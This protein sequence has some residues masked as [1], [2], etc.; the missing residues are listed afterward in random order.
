MAIKTMDYFKENG[1][2]IALVVIETGV[3]T[4]YSRS[5]QQLSR[6]HREYGR[7][8]GIRGKGLKGVYHSFWIGLWMRLPNTLQTR[9]RPLLKFIPF[10][11]RLS[12]QKKAKE[13]GIPTAIVKRHSSHETR[14]LLE[15]N[16]ISYVLLTDSSWLIKEPLLS[17]EK[18]KIINAHCAKLPRH[19]SLDALP[20]SVVENDKLGMTA[21]FVDDG[22]DT[23]PILLFIEVKPQKGDNLIT[24]RERIDNKKPEIFL[25]A[26]QELSNG[27]IYPIPQSKSEG[28][29]HRPMT[30]EELLKAEDVLQC[31]FF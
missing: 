26:I 18:T 25:K 8:M 15:K 7:I 1:I 27:I 14:F 29:N 13:L 30:V 16:D 21:H 17:M 11:N 2:D 31:R 23:G 5:E 10:L 20:W 19:R 12:L 22:I 3:R 24:L 4:K 6:A 28:V 9:I